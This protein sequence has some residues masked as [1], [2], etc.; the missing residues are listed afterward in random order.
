MFNSEDCGQ[1][2]G[3]GVTASMGLVGHDCIYMG[4][5][6]PAWTLHVMANK[7]LGDYGLDTNYPDIIIKLSYLNPASHDSGWTCSRQGIGVL[8]IL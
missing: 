2:S 5:Q 3:L 7:M 8:T 4:V 1:T 6:V